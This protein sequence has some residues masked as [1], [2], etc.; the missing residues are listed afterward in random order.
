[1]KELNNDRSMKLR[2]TNANPKSNSRS[3]SSERKRDIF[4]NAFC[5]LFGKSQKYKNN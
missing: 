3:Q 5:K 4:K 1:M 2:K